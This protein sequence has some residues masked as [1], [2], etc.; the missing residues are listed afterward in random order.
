MILR[1]DHRDALRR[2]VAAGGV[3]LVLALTVLAVCPSLH[4]WLHGEKQLDPDDACAVVLFVQGVTPALAA[5][6]LLLVAWRLLGE[7][8][9]TPRRLRLPA[10]PFVFPPGRGPPAS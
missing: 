3:A 2:G 7:T 1:P 4:A 6:A 5:L 10:L 9:P 8:L